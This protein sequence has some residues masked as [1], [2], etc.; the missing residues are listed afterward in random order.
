M[1]GWFRFSN[2]WE[3]EVDSMDR[4]V[5]KTKGNTKGVSLSFVIS[6]SFFF[7]RGKGSH[8]KIERKDNQKEFLS[9]RVSFL[10][11]S[12]F[13]SKGR[14]RGSEGRSSSACKVVF[15]SED[16]RESFPRRWTRGSTKGRNFTSW[17]VHFPTRNDVDR[18]TVTKRRLEACA[19]DELAKLQSE[20]ERETEHVD[21]NKNDFLSQGRIESVSLAVEKER[22]ARDPSSEDEGDLSDRTFDDEWSSTCD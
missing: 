6:K 4:I 7:F 15:F 17:Y 18:S 14:R 5:R 13:E 22:N 12:L 3:D 16:G 1:D 11:V 2:E 10:L 9:I 21:A 19:N 20:K 8:K